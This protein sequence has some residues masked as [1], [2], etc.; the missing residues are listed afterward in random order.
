MAAVRFVGSAWGVAQNGSVGVSLGAAFVSALVLLL[1]GAP[2]GIAGESEAATDGESAN[3]VGSEQLVVAECDRGQNPAAHA[4]FVE[5]PPVIDGR[6]DDVAWQQ[7][8]PVGELTQ[9]EPIFCTPPS[10][11]SEIRIVTD[12][13]MLYLSLRAFDPEPDKIVANRMGRS[14]I[15]F[16]DDNFTI[17]LDTFHDRQNGFFFQVNPNGGRRDGTFARDVFEEN[18][19]GIWYGDAEITAEGWTAEVAIPFKTLPFRPGADDWGLQMFR[20]IRRRNEE[21]RWAD[22]SRQRFGINMSRAG[23]LTGMAVAK[24]GVGL[25]VVPTF[26]VGASVDQQGDT[27]AFGM[28]D[29]D[30]HGEARI[31]PSFD[32]FYRVTPGLLLSAT[33]NTDFAQTEIDDAQV[34]LN[35]FA[36]FFPEKREFFLR[37]TG[38]FQFADLEGFDGILPFFSRRIGLQGTARGPRDVRL[39]GGGRLTGRA[40]RFNIGFMNLQQDENFQSDPPN[41]LDTIPD[42]GGENL[43]VARVSANVLEES[44]VGVLLTH[45]DPESDRENLLAGADFNYRSSQLIPG[46]FVSSSLWVQQDFS[47]QQYGRRETA[48]GATLSYPNDRVNWKLRVRDVGKNFDP[49]LGF[50]NRRDIRRYDAEYRYRWRTQAGLVRTWDLKVDGDLTTDRDD[51][52]ETVNLFVPFRVTTQVD[53]AFEILFYYSYDAPR[54]SFYIADH[55]GILPGR[56]HSVSG[57]FRVETSQHRKLRFRYHTGFGQ[58][59]GGVGLRIA[60]LVEWRPSKY[61][62]VSLEYD[63]RQF[64]GVKSCYGLIDEAPGSRNC[65]NE[66]GADIQKRG[67]AIQLARARLQVNFSPDIGWSTLV[68]WDNATDSAQFQTRLRWIVKPGREFFVVVGQNLDTK[69]GDIRVRE[70][71]P[72]AKVRWTFRF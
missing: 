23:T 59:F 13:E 52:I 10:F 60:P 37:D 9:V 32:A 12:G 50:V 38:I 41:G 62:L 34:N 42:R 2:L 29:S 47:G 66:P 28:R 22:P 70:T 19:D 44:N 58:L 8:T 24:Q 14:E 71:Q 49:A 6:L 48:W 57:I 16:Y 17:L 56:H 20:R 5:Q 45:G 11:K 1:V 63:R 40:G 51:N 31:E 72:T 54:R 67:F 55:I 36:L 21:H 68:Q 33:A 46:R 26:S 35:R 43:T 18:W 25:D 30:L 7:A 65:V 4:A 15:F 69:P 64:W 27:S 61:L 53:D 3:A 39:L